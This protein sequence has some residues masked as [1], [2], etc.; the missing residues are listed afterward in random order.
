MNQ[1]PGMSAEGE[2]ISQDF[3]E[4]VGDKVE[5]YSKEETGFTV[6]FDRIPAE[7]QFKIKL[8]AC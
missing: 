3:V 5:V 1:N 8:L 7:V 4:I 2:G 6:E